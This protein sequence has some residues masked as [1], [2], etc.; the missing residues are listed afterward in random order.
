MRMSMSITKAAVAAFMMTG[1][2]TVSAD[3]PSTSIPLGVRDFADFV[4][5][6]S[7]PPSDDDVA[8]CRA[9]AKPGGESAVGRAVGVGGSAI[10]IAGIG[11]GAVIDV[12]AH[13]HQAKVFSDCMTKRGYTIVREN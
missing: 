12:V 8:A 6:V 9:L 13:R 2:A 7:P 1:C 10:P 3:K 4:F 11:I 5:N